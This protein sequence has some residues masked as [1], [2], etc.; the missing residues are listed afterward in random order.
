MPNKVNDCELGYEVNSEIES[1]SH[2]LDN[3]VALGKNMVI[4]SKRVIRIGKTIR[5]GIHALIELWAKHECLFYSTHPQYL[6]KNSR[7]K[8]I[9]KIIEGLREENFDEIML[10]K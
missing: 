5:I 1:Q 3:P 6:N 4:L 9:Y 2:V 8:A 7:A 10:N